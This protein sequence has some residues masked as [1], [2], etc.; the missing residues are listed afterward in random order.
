MTLY[1]LV[2]DLYLFRNISKSLLKEIIS[3]F[4]YFSIFMIFY[5]LI[6]TESL[7]LIKTKKITCSLNI[8][9]YKIFEN[10]ISE[11]VLNDF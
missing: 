4:I 2:L 8:T 5:F 3:L 11:L 1:N 7:L 6:M 10:K 9:I